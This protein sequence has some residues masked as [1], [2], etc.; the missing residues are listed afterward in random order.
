[1]NITL[2]QSNNTN[3]LITTSLV[4]LGI[5]VAICIVGLPIYAMAYQAMAWTEVINKCQTASV[6]MAS[7]VLSDQQDDQLLSR[8]HQ[9]LNDSFTWVLLGF[10]ISYS[11]IV[12]T[13]SG[14]VGLLFSAVIIPAGI[15]QAT[16]IVG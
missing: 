9:D 12:R 7:R 14:Y 6:K 10:E 8:K 15:N 1:M 2:G 11:N 16:K 5:L 3:D 13:V 4:T